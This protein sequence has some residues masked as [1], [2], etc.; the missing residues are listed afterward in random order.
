MIN[1]LQRLASITLTLAICLTAS[2]ALAQ[3]ARV[4]P[5]PLEASDP[6]AKRAAALVTQM[7]AADKAAALKTLRAEADP[8]FLKNPN[9]EQTLDRQM[10]R[11]GKAKYTISRFERGLGDDVVVH[12]EAK[13]AEPTNIVI[14]FNE[15]K[16]I[17]GFA[18]VQIEGGFNG[19]W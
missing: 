6:Q 15:A 11:L 3:Q 9:M 7:L 8:S 12:L 13:D 19:R 17:S 16:K 5:T 4:S 14:R 1:T 2:S 10:A 18:Q